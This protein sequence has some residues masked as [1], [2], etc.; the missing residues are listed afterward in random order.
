MSPTLVI[1]GHWTG[2]DPAYPSTLAAFNACADGFSARKPDWS[3][4]LVP[5]GAGVAFTEALVQAQA[6]G[7]APIVVP[8]HE[9]STF[10]AG[11]RTL[12]AL[13]GGLTPLIEG[14]HSIDVD[15]GFGFLSA[16]SN[17]DL[18]DGPDLEDRLRRALDI[19]RATIAGRDVVVAASSMRPLLGLSSVLAL[20]VDL[21]ARTSQNR[22]LTSMLTRVLSTKAKRNLLASLMGD[23]A[24]PTNWGTA[25]GSGAAGGI[26]A[27]V[28][29]LGGRIVST[30]QFLRAICD[31]DSALADANLVIVAEP[32]L[33]SPSLADAS[34]DV[35][36]DVAGLYALPVVALGSE[37]SLAAHERAQ[38]GLHGQFL[39]E[40]TLTLGEAG[41][42]IARTWAR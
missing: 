30:G 32:R 16:L 3:I 10:D 18:S 38:W 39:T 23:E 12:D 8:I 22:Q 37:S 15:C 34:L 28:G 27:I 2:G 7:W 26:G 19:A 40:G 17:V 6:T 1:A 4:R 21:E 5:F 35:I 42:R 9:E 36:T 33:H 20:G 41:E 13:D 11:Q 24:A 14:G 29:A 31:L 25:P